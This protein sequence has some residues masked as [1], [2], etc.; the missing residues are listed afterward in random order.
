MAK[1]KRGR[2]LYVVLCVLLAFILTVL[3]GA[4]LYFRLPVGG[5]YAAS[6][7]AFTIPGLS[8]NFV[9]QGLSYD[10]SSSLFFVTGYQ[11]G[12][13]ASPVYLVNEA[14][15]TA[16][17]VLLTDEDGGDFTGHAG[18]LSVYGRFVYVAGGY[19]H[20]LYVYSRDAMIEAAEGDHIPLL[21]VFDTKIS[22]DD[23]LGVAFTAV[24]DGLLFVGEFYR[25]PNYPTPDSHKFTT[26]T[27]EYNQA[28]ALAYELDDRCLLG[29]RDNPVIALS[30]PDLVQGM[31]FDGERL[32]LSTSYAVA[33]SHVYAY[34]SLKAA[35]FGSLAIDGNAVPLYVLDRDSLLADYQFPPMA[36]EIEMV[37][38]KLYT[39]CESASNLYIFGK[40]TGG[41]WCYATDLSAME[42]AV[43]P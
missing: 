13:G 22:E 36:E 12:G 21:G 27:G 25:D 39:M 18:G 9:P 2:V 1:K 34:D 11:K 20:G 16:K 26:P 37:D 7:K 14:D 3:V 38:G 35:R 41:S 33:F 17:K 10:G 4:R 19:D 5:Y 32:Y 40:L 6:D 28:L 29:L 24:K 42:G 8:D 31:A 23:G 15:N 43:E 30:L